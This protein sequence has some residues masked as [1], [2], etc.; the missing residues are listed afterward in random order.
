MSTTETVKEIL[1]GAGADWVLWLLGA[2]SVVTVL[3]V[4]ERWLLFRSC[5]GNVQAMAESLHG[6]LEVGDYEEA[7]RKLQQ[8]RSVAG[9]IAVA[10]LRLAD[11]GP[12]A[13]EKAMQS[14]A[15]LQRSRLQQRLNYLGTIGNNAPFIGLLGTVLG[16]IR[17]FRDLSLD[18]TG[19]SAAVMAG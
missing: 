4:L 17:A 2:L 3:I 5:R 8:S 9:S 7:I 11:R 6:C 13:A 15:A 10:G 1:L 19:N 16:I 12:A 14:A 18:S